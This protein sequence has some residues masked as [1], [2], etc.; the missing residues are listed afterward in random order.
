L[1][2]AARVLQGR[3]VAPGV[4]AMIAPGSS[5]VRRE[6]EAEGLD[7]IFIEAGFEW[8]QSA[9]RCALP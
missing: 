3:K 4:R 9:V 1:R 6:A 2:D 7:R 8:R 5:T